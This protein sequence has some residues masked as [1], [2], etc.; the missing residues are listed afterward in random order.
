M[1]FNQVALAGALLMVLSVPCRAAP[2]TFAYKCSDGQL[3][4]ATYRGGDDLTLVHAGKR[5]ELRSAEAASGARYV[6]AG[7]QWW[8]WHGQVQLSKITQDEVA[9]HKIAADAGRICQPVH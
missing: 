5:L 4:M 7:L 1:K 3:F 9:R 8:E 2:R 6:G